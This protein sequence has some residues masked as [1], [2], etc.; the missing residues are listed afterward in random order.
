MLS[1]REAAHELGVCERTLRRYIA[2]GRLRHHR[3]PGGHFRIPVD[4]IEEFWQQHE[5]PRPTAPKRRSGNSALQSET[6]PLSAPESGF[7]S[8]RRRPPLNA[9][10]EREYSLSDERLAE[11]RARFA[12]DRTN[13]QG[14]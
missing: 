5:R 13:P 2:A 1:A 8:H 12:I 11:I 3:L 14:D 6:G 9:P 7:A 10:V 4:A